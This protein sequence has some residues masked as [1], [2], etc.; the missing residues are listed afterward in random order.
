MN[1]KTLRL[2]KNLTQSELAVRLGVKEST[3]CNYEK[4]T[5]QPNILVVRKLCEIL[6]CSPNELLA[7]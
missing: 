3:I 1:L 6:E 7:K 4:G 5:R 2:K